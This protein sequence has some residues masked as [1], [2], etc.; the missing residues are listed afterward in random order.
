MK[1]QTWPRIQ[2]WMKDFGPI[3]EGSF[4]LAPLT[5]FIGPNGSGKTYAAT[6]AYLFIKALE[7]RGWENIWDLLWLLTKSPLSKSAT[8]PVIIVPDMLSEAGQEAF[9]EK[10]SQFIGQIVSSLENQIPNY[11]GQDSIEPLVRRGG[12]YLQIGFRWEQEKRAPFVVQGGWLKGRGWSWEW[13]GFDRLSLEFYG[14][15]KPRRGRPLQLTPEDLIWAFQNSLGLPERIYY[16]PAA[17]A[18]LL[19]GW[20]VLAAMAIRWVRREIGIRP[21]QATPYTGVAGDFLLAL[22]E[23]GPRWVWQPIKDTAV[24]TLLEEILQ[25][26]VDWLSPEDPQL[27]V[28]QQGLRIPL[29][30]VSSGLAELAPIDLWLRKG[31]LRRGDW[32]I[33]EEPEAHLHPENQRRIATLMVRLVRCGVRVLCTTHSDIIL[34]QISNHLLLGEA[35]E[36]GHRPEGFDPEWDR[37]GY[38]EVGVYLFRMEGDG[39]VIEPVIPE[40]GFGIPEDEFVRVAEAIG[41]QTYSLLDLIESE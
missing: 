29:S 5:V 20:R 31:L 14:L 24:T 13:G 16:F 10:L 41:S 32:L 30:A 36:K 12:D 3:R 17:R 37:L 2:C 15:P 18:G 19:Q 25:G 38:G 22:L 33:I 11:F 4:D 39:S 26:Y 35:L 6:L 34:H 7:V 27:L 40:P 28:F 9:R 1:E 8:E 21:I 23:G